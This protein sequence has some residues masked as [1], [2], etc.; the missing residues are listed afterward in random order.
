MVNR[1]NVL[2]LPPR[3]DSAV[4]LPRLL[5]IARCERLS[6]LGPFDAGIPHGWTSYAGAGRWEARDGSLCGHAEFEQPAILRRE[7]QIEG[8]HAIRF[9]G[10]A[11]KHDD[12][13]ELDVTTNGNLN[14]FF[15]YTGDYGKTT[16]YSMVCAGLAGWYA[17]MSG[18]ERLHSA[19]GVPVRAVSCALGLESGRSYDVVAGRFNETSFVFV[20]GQ[21]VMALELAPGQ[22]D[23]GAD[24]VGLRHRRSRVAIGT[25]GRR[26][27]STV[28]IDRIEV[29]HIPDIA[30]DAPAP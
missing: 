30:V 24:A 25:W 13:T 12:E 23:A 2:T 7:Q 21:L 22:L 11:L 3:G 18:V 15:D 28:R 9:Q 10:A 17:G 19:L 16:T 29:F 26:G 6:Q 20:D 4:P 27:G 1:K 14:G 5:D 8:S